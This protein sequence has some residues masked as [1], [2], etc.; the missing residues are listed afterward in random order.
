MQFPGKNWAT[1]FTYD[2][3]GILTGTWLLNVNDGA[4]MHDMLIESQD[5]SGV[6]T[7]TGGWKAG[8]LPYATTW[9]LTGETDGNSV[10][11]IIIYQGPYNPGYTTT[12]TGTINSD[13]NSMSGTGTSGVSTWIA[14]RIL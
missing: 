9:N 1:Y 3:Q 6:L 4:H 8:S 13:W 14:T 5:L 2:V 10:E 7:G 11:F 12:L